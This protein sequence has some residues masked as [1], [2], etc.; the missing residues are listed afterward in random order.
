MI[1]LKGILPPLFSLS[2]LAIP[3]NSQAAKVTQ[4][5]SAIPSS[6]RAVTH[7]K[8]AVYPESTSTKDAAPSLSQSA[9]TLCQ[10][11]NL[12]FLEVGLIPKT[13]KIPDA[14]PQK[15]PLAI[16][17]QPSAVLL[18][19]TLSL[20]IPVAIRLAFERNPDLQTARLQFQRS[21]AQLKQSKAALFPS[22]RVSGSI[23]RTDGSSFSPQNRS[24]SSSPTSPQSI[25]SILQQQQSTTQQQLQQ[26]IST[27]QQRFQQTATQVQTNTLQQQI[28][29]LQQ[30]A[31]LSAT[32]PTSI[33][34][35]PL[36]AND[37]VLPLRPGSSAGGTGGYFNGAL[38]LNYNIFTG[39][40]RDASIQASQT[41]V[42]NAT[43]EIQRQLQRLRQLVTSNYYDLQQTQA[44]IA[45]A[46]GSVTNLT[47][48]L[49]IIQLGEQAGIRT[50]F[51][52]LQASVSL[53][54]A[55]QNQTQAKSL[56]TIARRQLAQQLN[57]PD[58]AD[59]TLPSSS[60]PEKAGQWPLSLEETIV[61]AL[62][63]RVELNQTKLQRQITQF[64]KKITAS[65]LRPQ[66]QSFVALNLADDLEDRFLGA[67]GYS[68]G[69]Q[70]NMSVF[71]GG[72]VRSQLRQFDKNIE[73]IDQQFSQLKESIRFEVEQAYFN[74][75]SD[76]T[77]ITTSNEALT[78]ATESLRL[79]QVRRDAGVGTTLE[80]TRSQ[81]DLAQAQSN[82]IKAILDY[83]RQLVVLE[84]ATGFVK[85]V[86]NP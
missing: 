51:E 84:R 79:A 21:C 5:P 37:V 63:N 70:M 41:Q 45:V 8:S 9:E 86:E 17:K 18:Q 66:I 49:R 46:D 57:L 34:L 77:N 40:Q 7:P 4:P 78:Q 31:S 44:L 60:K 36:T 38:S 20:N 19:N 54:D 29:Q 27:L 39:G 11:S 83:N 74:L 56:Y 85:I 71:E 67:Y 59:V 81:S 25:G 15:K 52:V 3:Q 50:R 1:K 58:T 62:N 64:Q 73:I 2:I 61:L 53:A 72:S 75:Q 32:L 43:L 12:S 26:D 76:A 47:E 42:K 24:Y 69:V 28:Q 22:L 65:Q 30:R 55:V 6:S 33:D 68:V 82:L 48:N 35:T 80:V 16:P 10:S 13:A 14:L 23:A